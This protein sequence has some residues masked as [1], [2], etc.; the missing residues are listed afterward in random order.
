MDAI[1]G[2]VGQLSQPAQ[3]QLSLDVVR[4]LSPYGA[5]A[6]HVVTPARFAQLAS[7]LDEIAESPS[8]AAAIQL[9]ESCELVLDQYPGDEPVGPG[10][11]TF[12][13]VVSLYYAAQTLSGD[14]C[15]PV[16]SAKRLVDALGVAQD[17]GEEGIYADAI[18]FLSN[19][20]A[21]AASALRTKV[22]KHATRLGTQ[23]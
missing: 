2:L 1:E 12:A 3:R 16:H 4:I 14:L 5:A 11:F 13:A 19:P 8:E 22:E 20:T 15:G 9:C 7:Q 6:P 18:E 23:G 17:E 21:I 10:W